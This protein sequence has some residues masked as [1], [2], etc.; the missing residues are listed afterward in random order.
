MNYK[1]YSFLSS[2]Y[3]V[4]CLGF[5]I[6][7]LI[8]ILF[9]GFT[10]LDGRFYPAI[11]QAISD[12]LNVKALLLSLVF[13]LIATFVCLVLAYPLALILSELSGDAGKEN[14]SLFTMIFILPMWMNSLIRTIAWQNLLEKT[15]IINRILSA[16]HLPALNIINKPEAVILGM[17][18]DFIPFMI[19]PIYNSILK[20]DKDYINAAKDLG[21]NSFQTL[22]K[23]IWPLS[24]PGVISGITMVFVPSLT[25]FAISDILGGGKI[26]LIGNIVEQLFTLD[27]D[28]HS[29]SALSCVLMV[30]IVI[31]IVIS[32]LAEKKN[33]DQ[34]SKEGGIGL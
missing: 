25:T 9:Y 3:A 8:I 12:P 32:D 28:W 21:A 24:L 2:P 5:I 4:W 6:I 17:V 30:F 1:K 23:V 18:Y 16:L 19:L 34:T 20:I 33:N 14:S 11:F 31:N 13:S 29:G 10:D 27:N 22:V 15:G 26:L 7:P